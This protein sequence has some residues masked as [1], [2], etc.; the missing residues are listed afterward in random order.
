M[1]VPAFICF[2]FRT[3]GLAQDL[4]QWHFCNPLLTT[5]LHYLC[6]QCCSLPRALAVPP[7]YLPR[8][9]PLPANLCC[10][11]G[12]P[13]VVAALC[14]DYKGLLL[15]IDMHFFFLFKR[16]WPL[17]TVYSLSSCLYCGPGPTKPSH[18]HFHGAH[19]PCAPSSHAGCPSAP[20][21]ACHVDHQ[22]DLHLTGLH[23][24][25]HPPGTHCKR[26]ALRQHHQDP[27]ICP[28]DWHRHH[29]ASHHYGHPG[30]SSDP[31]DQKP[32]P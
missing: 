7:I 18:T 29:L 28:A 25:A 6:Q 9:S 17:H 1:C 22:A 27:A 24:R 21:A 10:E 16:H 11:C 3:K 2:L 26:P 4:F 32:Q 31:S 8:A 5:W 19:R 14:V 13:S 30:N 12:M 15:V 20:P 23:H